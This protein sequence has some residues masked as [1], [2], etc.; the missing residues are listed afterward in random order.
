MT[1]LLLLFSLALAAAF[2]PLPTAAQ[3]SADSAQQEASPPAILVADSVFITPERQLI[4]EGNVEAYQG[5]TRLRAKKITFDRETDTVMI[6]GPIRIDDGEG[7]TILANYAELDRSLQ[8]GLLRGARMVMDRRLQL[9]SL[10]MTRVGGR[11]TQLFK[12]AVTSCRVCDD[13]RPPLWQ[14]RARKI[15]HDQEEQQLYFEDAQFRFLDVPI[16][17]LPG[18]RLPDPTLER[19]TGF[20]IPSV[21]STSNL[22]TGIKLPY[23][24]RLGDHADVTLTP[25]YSS[26]TRTLEYRYRQAFRKG[27]VG[28]EGAHTRDDLLPGEN[29]GYLFGLGH[30]EL[31]NAYQLDFQIQTTSDNAYLVD[32]GIT[33]LDRLRSE[34]TISR[35][36]RDSAIRTRLINYESL[37]DA[38]D[39]SLLAT[40][41]LDATVERRF[42]PDALGGEARVGLD[43]HAHRRAS[44]LDIVG[45]D[46]NRFTF[47]ADWRRS[48][49]LQRGL[50]ADWYVGFVGETF[51]ILQDSRFRDRINRGTPATAFRLSLPMTRNSGKGVTQFLEPVVQLGWSE[52]SG[53]PEPPND[54]SRF[55]EFDK[56]NLLALS[57]FPEGDRREEGL[58][59]AYGINWARFSTSGWETSASLGQVVR[60]EAEADFTRTSGLSGT[61]SDIL[62]A[63]QVRLAD[64]LSLTART[65]LD[66]AL[67]FSKA[68][69]RGDW[70]GNDA[71]LSGTYLWLGP[72]PVEGR[73]SAQ[74]EIWLDGSYKVAPGWTARANIRYD[75]SG[76]R[77]T[78]AGVGFLYENECV[79]VD[80]NV[81][82]RY[83]SSIS[84]EPTTDFG[85][86]VSLSGFSADKGTEKY[87]K[88][89]S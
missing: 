70:N 47:E 55:V 58:V 56:G 3:Q 42:F 78:R 11:Y 27:R 34:I 51:E 24:I 61:S 68:E 49:L 19:A 28:F 89:C 65:L 64:K 21:R 88:S 77:A 6:D 40:L 25:Y 67:E 18:M 72:D 54:E 69:L 53:D 26:R 35:Y 46:V 60:K 80:V 87:E 45:R 14:I 30:F 83:T 85:F 39:E 10:Q 8:N 59:L 12:T 31:P 81:K 32:Y 20:L 71:R 4:A 36:K 15:T 86:T 5:T 23:F 16:F 13:G 17:Y 33:D 29:R 75:V 7:I 22:S 41:V 52:T 84:V 74:S 9:A 44:E 43:V 48:W 1:R 79:A 62:I 2:P 63:G 50:R 76:S 57:R 73:T 38:D 82:R 37:R 66:N